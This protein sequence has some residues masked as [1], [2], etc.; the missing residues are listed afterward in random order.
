MVDVS[1][2]SIPRSINRLVS[3]KLLTKDFWC[4]TQKLKEE[5]IRELSEKDLDDK[6]DFP[7]HEEMYDQFANKDEIDLGTKRDS[8]YFIKELSKIYNGIT[9]D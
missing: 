1:I 6:Y 3:I 7:I 5:I 8:V 4:A 9:N 2:K